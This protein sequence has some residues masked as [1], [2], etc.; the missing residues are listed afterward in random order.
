MRPR[1]RSFLPLQNCLLFYLNVF[2]PFT[3]VS[4]RECDLKSGRFRVAEAPLQKY[5]QD[6][7]KPFEINSLEIMV[8]GALQREGGF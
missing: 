3:K 2:Q 6:S 4:R 7:R 1:E 8:K 5:P